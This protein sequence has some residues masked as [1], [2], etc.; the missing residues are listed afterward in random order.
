MIY[1]ILNYLN[2]IKTFP[3]FFLTPLVYV[4]GNSCEEIK[5]AESYVSKKKKKLIILHPY[6]LTFFLKYHICN[7]SLF[8]DL[9][10]YK[11]TNFEKILKSL[12]NFLLDKEFVIRRIFMIFLKKFTKKNLSRY[13]FPI[14]G[15]EQIFGT[16]KDI[17]DHRKELIEYEKIKKFF[18]K[19]NNFDLNYQKNKYCEEKLKKF[20]LPYE[21]LVLLHVRDGQYRKDQGRKDYR[22]S[23]INSYIESIKFLINK[24]YFVI[25]AGRK[26]MNKI[27]FK[28]KN[29]LDYSTL[30]LQEDVLDLFLMKKAKFFIGTQ[31]GILDLAQLFN[32]PILLTNMIAIF[33]K[34]PFKKND[35]GIFRSMKKNNEFL[36]IKDFIKLN[37]EYHNLW[38]HEINDLIFYENT[39]EQIYDSLN[40]F[41]DIQQNPILTK[42]QKKFNEFILSEHKLHYSNNPNRLFTDYD[43]LKIARLVKNN[44]GCLTNINLKNLNFN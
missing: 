19:E 32:K 15:I 13:N 42:D 41:L 16:K 43:S 30:D 25:R 2:K 40:E 3:Y 36:H 23:D 27:F 5:L 38:T 29:F 6:S 22:N 9:N 34:Y 11:E 1:F 39:A 7:K 26:P 17:T 24:G 37:Y 33:S 10:Y 31:S 28:D 18:V 8:K 20:N 35:R 4:I 12:L 21:R 44:E 14:I